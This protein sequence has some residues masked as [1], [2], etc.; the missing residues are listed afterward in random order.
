MVKCNKCNRTLANTKYYLNYKKE[1]EQVLCPICVL[2]PVEGSQSKYW[3]TNKTKNAGHAEG[4][5]YS[6]DT[7]KYKFNWNKKKKKWLD[8]NGIEQGVGAVN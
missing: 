3:E 6:D 2:G 5:R 4:F 1:N 8:K 7:A